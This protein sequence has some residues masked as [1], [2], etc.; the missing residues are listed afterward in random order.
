MVEMVWALITKILVYPLADMI[1]EV[2]GF[3]C[4][5]HRSTNSGKGKYRG[6]GVGLIQTSSK[7]L[8]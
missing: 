5:A 1:D 4:F 7:C 2:A 3:Q 6:L 8:S